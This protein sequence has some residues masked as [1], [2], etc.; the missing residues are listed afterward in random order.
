MRF[1]ARLAVLAAALGGVVMAPASAAALDAA[2]SISISPPRPPVYVNDAFAFTGGGTV[3]GNDFDYEESVLF[4]PAASPIMATS[5]PQDAATTIEAI[6]TAYG[7]YADG[8][9]SA[10]GFGTALGEFAGPY[11]YSAA[12]NGDVVPQVTAP[13]MF[14]ACAYL[15]DAGATLAVSP[16]P[17]AFTVVDPPGT[18]APP[19]GFGGPPGH[20][21]RPADETLSVRAPRR[22][23]SP[24]RNLLHI[25]GR[26]SVTS[27]EAGLAV[28]LKRTSHYNGC[29]ANDEQDEQ[30][31]RADGGAVISIF[32]KVEPNSVGIFDTPVALHFRR[33]VRGT[34]VLCAYLTQSGDDLAVGYRRFTAPAPPPRRARPKR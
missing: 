28:T 17:V 32:E 16:A 34:M 21:H 18:A 6:D 31:T 2:D 5:C 13:G 14:H 30:I 26:Y 27:G 11:T 24:G 22:I 12:V 8:S 25:R 7:P 19:Q 4:V 33:H 23:D 20:T 3:D 1:S 10:V 15:T 29:A 9:L